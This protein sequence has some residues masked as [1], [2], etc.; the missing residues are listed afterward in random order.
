M[1]PWV[2]YRWVIVLGVG[3]VGGLVASGF[4]PYTPLHAVA[5]DRSDSFAIATGASTIAWKPYTASIL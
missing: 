5:T 2:K 1:I 3:F 4:W